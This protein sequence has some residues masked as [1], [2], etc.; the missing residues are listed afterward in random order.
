MVE[1]ARRHRRGLELEL[2]LPGL[3]ANHIRSDRTTVHRWAIPP[4]AGDPPPVRPSI[5]CQVGYYYEGSR[6]VQDIPPAEYYAGIGVRSSRELD[7]P[8]TFAAGIETYNQLSQPLRRK[9]LNSCQWLQ[10]SHTVFFSSK[11]ASYMALVLAVEALMPP[12][13][14][15]KECE[16]CKRR[17]GKGPTQRFKEFMAKFAPPGEADSGELGLFYEI[18]SKLVHGGGLLLSDRE[19][20]GS[21]GLEGF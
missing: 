14:S 9:F 6:G 21:T 8:A 13:E 15:G 19:H 10:H 17:I 12:P 1:Q 4:V 7:L 3:V 5:L 16:T 20:L 11:S 18:R 2:L